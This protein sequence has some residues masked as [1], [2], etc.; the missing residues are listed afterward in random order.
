M[1]KPIIYIC[2]IVLILLM[3]VLSWLSPLL[4][5]PIDPTHTPIAS[6]LVI[7]IVAG[8]VF[9]LSVLLVIRNK[10]S[11]AKPIAILVVGAAMRVL[12]FPST[13]IL[14][15]DFYRYLWD[16]AVTANSINPYRYAPR[17]VILRQGEY[18]KQLDRLADE[19]KE[20]IHKINHPQIR[21]IYP[22]VAQEIF[23]LSYLIKPWSITV[24]RTLILLFD[25]A[26]AV[27]LLLIL[28]HLRLP[29]VWVIIYWW[30]PLVVKELINACHMDIFALAPITAA[31]YSTFRQKHLVATLCIVLAASVKLW[32]IVFLFLLWRPLI[33]G[34]SKNLKT[35]LSAFALAV[36]LAFP[37]VHWV[38]AGQIGADSGFVTYSLSWQNNDSIFRVLRSILSMCVQLNIGNIY[39]VHFYTRFLVVFIYIGILIVLFWKPAKNPK[40]LVVKFTLATASLFLLSPTQFPWYYLWIVPFLT[41]KPFWPLLL[42][43]P[44]LPIY[45]LQYY[46]PLVG[47]PDLFYDRIVWFEHFPIWIAMGIEIY[48]RFRSRQVLDSERVI[49]L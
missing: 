10:A 4:A 34:D 44:L 33:S 11:I 22:P 2:G 43:C 21:T 16:G 20:I 3:F 17:N 27:F 8:L 29:I 25:I 39:H 40:D 46:L 24:F 36:G 1:A 35:L 13:P 45:Y 12:M 30:N 5:H 18:P 38:L 48:C 7:Y 28:A 41:L 31:L 37:M 6:F 14:E 26:T 32:P 9:L 19:S 15:D 47:H 42:Y 23:A 49:T